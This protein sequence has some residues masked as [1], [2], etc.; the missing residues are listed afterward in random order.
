MTLYTAFI[1]T[2]G[3]AEIPSILNIFLI[4]CALCAKHIGKF[5]TRHAEKH[6]LYC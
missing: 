3:N 5:A 6:S 2:G 1:I 4:K